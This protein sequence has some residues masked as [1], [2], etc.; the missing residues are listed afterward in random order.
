MPPTCTPWV[1]ARVRS[2]LVAQVAGAPRRKSM[3]VQGLPS[4]NA[5]G[6]CG[7]PT[8]GAHAGHCRRLDGDPCGA[9]RGVARTRREGAGNP[10][11]SRSPG[12]WQR[13]SS[14]SSSWSYRRA[15]GAQR[16][17]GARRALGSR[18]E[19]GVRRRRKQRQPE[20]PSWRRHT[21]SRREP[22]SSR[23]RRSL[24]ECEPSRAT[25]RPLAA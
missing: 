3:F 18:H 1:G 6:P 19:A 11:S 9:R 22:T 15:H 2:T 10:D 4:G 21:W 14:R 13:R 25:R 5:P 20:R 8:W 23:P 24:L 17:H 16:A 12:R 7:G